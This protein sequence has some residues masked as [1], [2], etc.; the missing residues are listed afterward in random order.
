MNSFFSSKFR[1]LKLISKSKFL[2]NKPIKKNYLIIDARNKNLLF[3]Y[4]DKKNTNILYTR[5]EFINLY[6]LF[7]T[8]FSFGFKNIHFNYIKSFIKFSEPKYCI[9]LNHPKAY[10]Y[11]IKNINQNIITIAFQNGHTFI[12]NNKFIRDLKIEKQKNKLSTDYIFTIN[13][14]FTE[15]LFKKY[16]KSKYIEIGSFKN[17]FYFTKKIN[18]KR[19][20]IAFISQWRTPEY[21][22]KLKNPALNTFYNTTKKILPKLQKFSNKNNLK[23]EIFGS[24]W[25][26]REKMFYSKILRNNNWIFRKRKKNNYSYQN[27]DKVEFVV[28]VDSS[29]GFESLARGNKTISFYFQEKFINAN[30]FK[31]FGFNFLK[32]KGK[33]W[34]NENSDKEFNRLINYAKNISLINWKKNNSKTIKKIMEHDSDNKEFQKI[35]LNS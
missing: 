13:K 14:Y 7:Y 1:I 5:G 33:F 35:I 9:T 17:N 32:N 15:N 4:I 27:T 25:D 8:L 34:T 22:S 18:K 19:K 26:T 12:F 6:V 28:F 30:K 21:L 20:S 3:R 31:G 11:K 29:L 23:L 2:F 10:F 16:I 24:E